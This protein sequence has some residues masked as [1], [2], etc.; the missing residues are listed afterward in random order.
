MMSRRILLAGLSAAGAALPLRAQVFPPRGYGTPRGTSPFAPE[1]FRE[2]RKK[3]MAQLGGGVAVMFG[4]G[5]VR[6]NSAVEAPF[7][8]DPDFAWLTGI[9]DEPDAVLVLAPGERRVR[10]MLLLQSRDPEAER[11]DHERVPLGAE[12]ERRTG[13]ERVLRTGGLGGLVTGLA[14]RQKE[15]HFLGPVVGPDSPV[16]KSLDLYGKIAQ[17]V[18]GVKTTDNSKLL[19]GIRVVKEERELDLIRKAVAATARG[20]LAGMRGVRPGWTE[21][22]LKD[23]IEAGFREG[24]GEGL[25]YN[26]IVAAGRNAYSLHYVGGSGPVRSG[27]MI[28]VDAGATVGGYASDITRTYPASGRFTPKQRKDYELVLEAQ[29]AAASKLKAGVFF[30]DLQEASRDV[31]RRAGRIDQFT[32]GLGHHV[33]LHVHDAADSS[34]PIPA[35]AVL[36]IEPGLYVQEENYGIRVEDMYLVTATGAERMSVAIPRTVA[37]VEG[38]MT[39]G[40]F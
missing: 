25:A 40:R 14:T 26:S 4:A 30:E 38:F 21:S 3:V 34:K 16:P 39:A 13:F 20:H 1:V 31:F 23:V 5:Q 29:E 27:E 32:H 9:T 17:R 24:G 7:Y 28:L 2:R 8:Q 15:L 37:E 18:P 33:G 12:I 11:W 6:T 19:A 35:G 36:T 22:R 10:E